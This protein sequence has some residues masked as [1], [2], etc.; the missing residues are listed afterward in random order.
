MRIALDY[1][2]GIRQGAGVGQYVRS[3]VDAMLAQDTHNK[4]TLIASG[5]P[6]PEHPFPTADN[7]R[8][9]GIG[10]PDRYLNILWYRWRVPLYANYF[11]GPADIYHGLD[12]ALPP[13]SGK[14]R[15]IV[16]VYDLAFVEHP[17]AAVPSLVA[18]LNKVVP[19]SVAAA[20]VVAAIS[21]ATKQTLIEHYQTPPEKIT[22]VP[23]GVAPHYQPVTDPDFLE[24]TRQ[25]FALRHPFVLGV[26][27]LEP[28][29]N[30]KGLIQAFYEAQQSKDGP[31]M[32]AIAGGKGWLYEETQQLVTELKLEDKVHFLGRVS[33]QELLTL[34]SLAD[35]FA[36][37]SFFEGFGIPPLE[38]MACGAPVITSNTSSLPEVAGNAALLVD[39]YDPHTIAQAMLRILQDAPL[40]SELQRQGYLQAQRYTW[41]KAATKMLSVYQQVCNGVTNF[42]EDKDTCPTH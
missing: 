3:L 40:R 33:E 20:D 37:P 26:G 25:K 7:A 17:E 6:T 21:Y 24:A 1:T 42:S 13:I 22:V 41:S 4:Y 36:F 38:A 39:P 30:H 23:C 2:A 18:Y 32:L 29:K 35:V 15:K 28:R 11:T 10:I 5:R 8:S 9:R 34:Y 16:T 19:A 14:T 12:F 27:T 31:A